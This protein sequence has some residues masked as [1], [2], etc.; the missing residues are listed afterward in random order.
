MRIVVQ[1]VLEASV[2]VEGQVV[3]AIGKGFLILLGVGMEDT[4]EIADKYI[5]K[6]LKLRIFQDQNGKTN[7]SL[8][9]VEGEI[10]VV[11]QFTLYADCRRGN[12]PDFTGAGNAILARELYEYFLES[13]RDKLGKVEGGAFGEDM[14]VSLIN[15]G[16]FTLV[17][18]EKL[19]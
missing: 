4:K 11:S 15:D 12:R 16:P 2:A 10:L 13:I 1:R 9:D 6:I 3:G 17:L 5:D 8:K 14:K 19:F 18:D 7:L